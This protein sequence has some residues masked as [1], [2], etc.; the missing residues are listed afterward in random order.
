MDHIC[1]TLFFGI[2]LA[3][4]DYLTDIVMD[5][6]GT[7]ASKTILNDLAVGVLGSA[8]VFFYRKARCQKCKFANAKERINLIGDLNRGIRGA[9]GAVI[10]SALSEDKSTRLRG[11]DEATARIDTFLCGLETAP[12]SENT[13]YCALLSPDKPSEPASARG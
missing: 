2:L 11:L 10:Q 12:E 8:A 6:F 4:A 7:S 1:P 9:L 3:S 13:K 5:Y